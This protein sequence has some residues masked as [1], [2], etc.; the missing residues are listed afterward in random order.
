[1]LQFTRTH[2]PREVAGT[3]FWLPGAGDGSV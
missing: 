1:M 2:L 3:F